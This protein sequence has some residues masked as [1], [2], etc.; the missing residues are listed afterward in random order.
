M[1]DLGTGAV[2]RAQVTRDQPR[3]HLHHHAEQTARQR[4]VPSALGRL[5][6]NERV[7]R[8]YL[9]ELA[10]SALALGAVCDTQNVR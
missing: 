10:M 7:L 3:E 4:S 6:P 8:L 2:P 1:L 5:V 9:N